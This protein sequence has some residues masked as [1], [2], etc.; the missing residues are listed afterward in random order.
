MSF[1]FSID[2]R[3]AERPPAEAI[4]G[5]LNFSTGRSEA[6][7]QAALNALFIRSQPSS[8]DDVESTLSKELARL[9]A[10]SP[11][12]ADVA[13]ARSVLSLV[14]DALLPAYLRHHA[15]LLF[16]LTAAD[17]LNP[18]F[19]VRL[20]EAV[21]AAGGPWRET[22]RVIATALS[23]LND[24]VGHRPIAVLE[25]ER[26]T[27]VYP[28]ERFRPVP[29]FLRGAGVAVGPYHDLIRATL[30]HI[31]ATPPDLLEETSFDPQRLDE[32]ALD[33]RAHDAM[34]PVFKRTNYLFGE[35]DPHQID[36]HGHYRRFVVRKV[37]LDSLVGW[38][39]SATDLPPAER[40][41]D[42]SAV[43]C[44]TILMASAISG[45]GPAA[46]DSTVSLA[47]LLPIV[48]RQRDAFYARTMSRVK[49]ARAA[50]LAAIIEATRQP[51][52]HVRQQLNIDLANFAASQMQRRTVAEQFAR[53]GFP[54]AARSEAEHIPAASVRIE[55]ELSI[56]LETALRAAARGNVVEAADR[57][58]EATDL[59]IRGVECGALIDPWNILGFQGIF[60]LFIAR[61]DA[62]PDPRAE[63]L[64]DLMGRLFAAGSHVLTEA[65]AL[66][67]AAVVTRVRD[68]LENTAIWWDR[69]ATTTVS[70]LPV[71]QGGALALSA[72]A[73]A[74]TIAEWRAAG[75]A[76]G[77]LSFWR[78]RVERLESPKAFADVVDALLH[79][80]DLVSASG[81]LVQW[82][83]EADAIGFGDDEHSFFNLALRWFHELTDGPI[84][85]PAHEQAR[86]CRRFFD[87]LEANAGELW[88]V[89][90]YGDPS[91]PSAS[92]DLPEDE[93][94][95]SRGEDD[96][97]NLF[98]AAYEGMIY[99]DSTADGVEG[100]VLD[101]SPNASGGEFEDR[102]KQL[103]PRLRFLEML[104]HLWRLAAGRIRGDS[105]FDGAARQW[106][107]HAKRMSD[108]LASL[109]QTVARQPLLGGSGDL[110]SNVEYD[111]QLQSK[112]HLSH[113]IANAAVRM[114]SAERL[115]RSRGRD[116]PQQG[117]E[118]TAVLR[119]VMAGDVAGLRGAL[120]GLL[121]H[122]AGQPLLYVAVENGGDP[123][124]VIAA[125]M[126]HDLL[127][128]LAT[129][130]PRLGLLRET[131]QVLLTALRME[132]RSRPGGLSVTEFD[133]LYRTTLD[134]MFRTVVNV[135]DARRRSTI[136][137]G[138][139]RRAERVLPYGPAIR[140][141]LSPPQT[142]WSASRRLASPRRELTV[143]NRD[144]ATVAM[145]AA[146]V[147][148]Y[149]GLWLRH[150]STMRLTAVEALNDS[151]AWSEAKRFIHRYGGELFHARVLPLS[152]LRAILAEGVETF[153]D[154][155]IEQ[156]DPLHP[157]PLVA[158]IR[159]NERFR[160]QA[161]R[162]LGLI[163]AA[164]VDEIERF[165]EYNS[166][167]T[168]SDYGERFDSFLDFLRLESAYRRD[169]WDLTPLRIAHE[170]L[171]STGRDAAARLW[172]EV[173]RERTAAAAKKHRSRLQS[174][175][176][177]HAMRLPSISDHLAEEFVKPFAIDRILALVPAAVRDAKTG[178]RDSAAFRTIHRE[179]EDYLATS[180]GSAAELPEWLGRL[181]A[182]VT[183]ALSG[184][185]L[186]F[187]ERHTV[188]GRPIPRLRP[189]QVLR[190]I[191]TG[192][193]T[194]RRDWPASGA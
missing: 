144:E 176:K 99:R 18:F 138:R 30:E 152:N 1:P 79:R 2:S 27:E 172:E 116:V 33:V 67:D 159:Q 93:I 39:R 34:H 84:A 6:N 73:V 129:E 187:E 183:R 4:L 5:Y 35:W 53:M 63:W 64:I 58:S 161:A 143:T 97:E 41:H 148:R 26:K 140:R 110:E 69:F 81:L 180:T 87:F 82:L 13:Q 16:H 175:E 71:V 28:H 42:A 177:R 137:G 169:E 132:R 20:F 57:L 89:P 131:R 108:D 182:A 188:T 80:G 113:L 165:V 174:L 171:A 147:D 191:T 77:D 102:L 38:M 157:S 86:L 125:R 14:F 94:A 114:A 135:R 76:A 3:A 107:A 123:N 186:D 136:R 68:W 85:R 146:V 37:I 168:Q 60:P 12:F 15:D 100:E 23:K 25:N 117:D 49:G 139:A 55:C 150:A 62:V 128:I 112:N 130:L 22:E 61:E 40:L 190:Q 189:A 52:G 11:A 170:V 54:E 154:H 192:R 151:T 162:L 156:D 98:G 104:A 43:L 121:R 24:Y 109:A 194:R 7:V 124:D 95:D 66:G 56:R 181:D 96:A 46:H 115:L 19:L 166:T 149:A 36:S 59:I 111:A 145:T 141:R 158:Q 163:Y 78:D 32:L 75:R 118:A 133:R 106:R 45:W 127:T 126:N 134:T 70:D 83:S 122:L 9:S 10:E 185:P 17:L 47:S 88:I 50:R 103:E 193:S 179:L 142:S 119:N 101:S 90:M 173:V 72:A 31:V 155:L 44:G 21:L 65:A 48:A 29:L 91:L 153:L 167:T 105:D 160:H 184:P 51:F 92:A 178:R 8:W 74:G 164:V 120:P